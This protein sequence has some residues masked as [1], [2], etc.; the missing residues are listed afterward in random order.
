A[1]SA[2]AQIS[3]SP[4]PKTPSSASTRSSPAHT[5]QPSI[6][7][8][9]HTLPT[10]QI[11]PTATLAASVSSLPHSPQLRTA[12]L[13]PTIATKPIPELSRERT[14]SAVSSTAALHALANH[15]P[16]RSPNQTRS[17][18]Q[19]S[20]FPPEPA[21][22]YGG[23]IYGGGAGA[24]L[25]AGAGASGAYS[26]ATVGGSN[27]MYGGKPGPVH[28]LL[29]APYMAT[30]TSVGRWYSPAREAIGRVVRGKSGTP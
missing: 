25:Y 18:V 7:S 9:I 19:A 1:H 11:S 26:H 6:S 2:Q 8:S 21:D 16:L 4:P 20:T 29:P 23:G 24:G 10:L 5:R 15:H 22:T 13:S 28:A 30:H 3:S 27:G 14:L 17:A 12:A